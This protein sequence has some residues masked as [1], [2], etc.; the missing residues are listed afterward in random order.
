M[1]KVF[2]NI[3]P[4]TMI[5]VPQRLL[6]PSLPEFSFLIVTATSKLFDIFFLSVAS[7]VNH[8]HTTPQVGGEPY[9]KTKCFSINLFAIH[10][11]NSTDLILHDREGIKMF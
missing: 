5:L 2:R 3:L 1:G 4:K 8:R 6:V 9:S 10:N 7:E 11:T